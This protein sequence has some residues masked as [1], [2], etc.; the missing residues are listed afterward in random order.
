[1][2]LHSPASQPLPQPAPFGALGDDTHDRPDGE[3]AVQGSL[4]KRLNGILYRNGPGRFH[5]GGQSKRTVLDG[6]GV[7]Q[8]LQL[9][10]GRAHYAR[11]F[12]R[13]PKFLAEDA[14]NR[15]L[16]PTWTTSL[17]GLLPNLRQHIQGQAGVTTYQVNGK[18]L[19]LDEGGSPGFGIDRDSLATMGPASLGLP[20]A[21]AM[22]KAHA[23]YVAATGDWLFASTRYGFKGML[24]DLVRHRP[25]GTRIATPT[26]VSPRLG[27]VHDFAVSARHA[28]FNLQ[29]V[30]LHGLRYLA[31]LASF[32]ECLE[33]APKMGNIVLAID[34]DTGACRSFEAP[35]AWAWHLANAYEHGGDIVA[36]FVGYD[37]PG[38]FLG[39]HAQLAA[40]MRGEDGVHGAAGTLRRYV[41]TADG[42]LTETIMAEGNFEFP[43]VDGRVGAAEHGRIYLTTGAGTGMLHT[44]IAA[45]DTRSGRLDAYDFGP[46]V[47]AGEPVFAADPGRGIDQGWL[48]T[49]ILDT[50]SGTSGFAVLDARNLAAGPVATVDLGETMPLSFHGCWVAGVQV[51]AGGGSPLA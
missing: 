15:F 12:V 50:A 37:D 6:D 41:M 22:P 11:R 44:G 10:D 47:N 7:I 26:V 1:M 40:I 9:A 4:P 51:F 19:A 17:P 33:W 49:Q 38:H 46:Q 45:F 27:Y 20:D 21:D 29:A 3:L 34:L 16:W 39:P 5:R 23:R 35:A 32:T 24:I 42:R 30:R 43:S 48:L 14:A 31:G 28:V 13:T 36:D 18:L 25:D 8:R 2:P